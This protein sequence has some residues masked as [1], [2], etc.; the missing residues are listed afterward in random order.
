[1]KYIETRILTADALRQTCIK[2]NWYTRGTCREYEALFDK[3]HDGQGHQIN[4]TTEKLVEIAE[5][6]WEHSRIEEYRL[7]D[8]LW[9]LANVCDTYF[10]I[11]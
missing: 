6:I 3:L 8:V 5:D 1:M 7:E 4:M 11:A 10:G 2:H 9:E